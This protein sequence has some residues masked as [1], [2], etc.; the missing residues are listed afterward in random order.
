MVLRG[1][2]TNATVSIHSKPE[3][4]TWDDEHEITTLRKYYALRDEAENV[5][6]IYGLKDEEG[7]SYGG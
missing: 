4:S 5:G 1:Q 2:T 7:S 3:E 6:S